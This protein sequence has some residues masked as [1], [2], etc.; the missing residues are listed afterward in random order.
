MCVWVC[1]GKEGRLRICFRCSLAIRPANEGEHISPTLGSKPGLNFA[2]S[3][4][5][6]RAF[7]SRR[8]EPSRAERCRARGAARRL[9]RTGQ[10][11]RSGGFVIFCLSTI[12]TAAQKWLSARNT[13][14][15]MPPYSRTPFLLLS[16]DPRAR[17]CLSPSLFLGSLYA[18]TLGAPSTNLMRGWY[19][20]SSWR[21]T[22]CVVPETT[23]PGWW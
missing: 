10:L 2:P 14:H 11:N 8:A 4:M 3:I 5:L 23:L 6:I 7:A 15:Y 17:A 21:T 16:S 12:A 20:M 1:S 13:R 22:R 18:R 19:N 9:V